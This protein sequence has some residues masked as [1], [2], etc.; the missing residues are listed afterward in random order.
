[1][2]KRAFITGVAGQDGSYLAKLLLNNGYEV[3]GTDLPH[4]CEHPWRHEELGI[5]DRIRWI[6]MDLSHVES[7]RSVLHDCKPDEIYNFAGQ[8]F[9]GGG[10][11][12]S[13]HTADSTAMSVVRLLEAIRWECPDVRFFQASSSEMF[14]DGTISPQNEETPFAPRGSYGI[15]KMFAHCMTVHYRTAFNLHASC[16]ILFNHESPLR[17]IHFLTRKVTATLARIQCGSQE[18]LEVGRLDARRD[19]G[20]AGDYVQGIWRMIQESEPG[21]YVLATGETHTVRSFVETAAQAAGM[22]IAWDGTGMNE[23]GIDR[24]SGRILVRINPDYW[25]PPE[26]IVLQGYASKAERTL[27]WRPGVAFEEWVRRMVETDLNR[28][29]SGAILK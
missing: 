14:G 19:W 15:S 27:S 28:V 24:R 13:L 25:R 10:M 22:E 7:I 21:D 2:S 23:I 16:G 8:S 6:A 3:L 12:D 4:T 20:Y 29:K 9:V 5:R 11:E 18:T 1:M 17:A 26:K